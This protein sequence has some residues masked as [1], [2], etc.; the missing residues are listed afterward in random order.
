M[1]WLTR[2]WVKA[3]SAFRRIEETARCLAENVSYRSTGI[4]V[5]GRGAWGVWGWGP[6]LW[7]FV[8]PKG[9]LPRSAPPQPAAV[10]PGRPLP[11][12]SAPTKHRRQ[13]PHPQTQVIVW[14]CT[15]LIKI[16]FAEG[17]ALATVHR[18]GDI[19]EKLQFT[20]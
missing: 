18:R 1:V 14:M 17:Q 16:T 19:I 2:R 3:L 5:G 9:G 15:A 11:P 20:T 13:N 12:A 7:C 4:K 6:C 10:S 8:N